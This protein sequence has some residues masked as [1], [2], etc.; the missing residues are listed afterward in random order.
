M[1]C[2]IN[3]AWPLCKGEVEGYKKYKYVFSLNLNLSFCILRR[4]AMSLS[5]CYYYKIVFVLLFVAVTFL[6]R[7]SVFCHHFICVILLLRGNF[8]QGIR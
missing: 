5:V 7:L 1:V 4:E 3:E 2:N 8:S 6:T